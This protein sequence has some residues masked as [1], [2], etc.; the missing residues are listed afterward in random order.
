M[1]RSPV[2]RDFLLN[3]RS[4]S[5]FNTAWWREFVPHLSHKSHAPALINFATA[6][7]VSLC[8]PGS[9]CAYV[10]IVVLTLA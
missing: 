10:F 6:S 2:E 9:A 1:L 7:A 3:E 8:H 5:R 4:P